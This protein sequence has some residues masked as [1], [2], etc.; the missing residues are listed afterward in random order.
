PCTRVRCE[1]PEKLLQSLLPHCYV[2]STQVEVH[3]DQALLA[4]LDLVRRANFNPMHLLSVRFKDEQHT[5]IA[6]T[7][8]DGDTAKRYFLKLLMQQIQNSVVFEGPSGSKNLALD[9]QAESLDE[10]KEV[11]KGSWEYLE[12]A[13]CNRPVTSLE[14]RDALVEDLVSFT[15]ITRMQLPLQR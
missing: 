3:G 15:M 4:G 11:M 1:T 5:T 7:L 14:E 12:L 13:G 2:A 9:S 10:V 6:S 8:C